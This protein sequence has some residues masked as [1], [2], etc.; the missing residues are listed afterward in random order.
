[1]SIVQGTGTTR[2]RT[3]NR[4]RNFLL[5]AALVSIIMTLGLASAYNSGGP[6]STMGHSVEELELDP[7]YIDTG[8]DRIGIGVAGPD[9]KVHIQAD[10]AN[11]QLKLQRTGSLT[12]EAW[13]YVNEDVLRFASD[14]GLGSP[15]YPGLMG[16]DLSTG[17]VGIGA[18]SPSGL[19][20]VSSGTS[21]DAE[22][23]LEAD[24]D[25]NNENDNP[26]IKLRQDG[27]LT[28]LNFGFDNSNFGN[29]I[30][31]IGRV[32]N[33]V[34]YWDTLTIDTYT[35]NIGINTTNP[36]ETLEVDGNILAT[37][38]VCDSV[39]CIGSGAAGADSDWAAVGGGDPTLG[40]DIYH[41]GN[42]GIGTNSP[43]GKL[44]V[45]DDSAAAGIP[46]ILSNEDTTIGNQGWL[47]FKSIDDNSA[48]MN[49]AGIKTIYL[50]RTPGAIEGRLDF[51]VSAQDGSIGSPKLSILQN[52]NVGIG[53][54]NP[55]GQLDIEANVDTPL[56][57]MTNPADLTVDFRIDAAG[58][59]FHIDTNAQSD[60]I[61]I[62]GPT[63]NV[64][65]GT[66]T[67]SQSWMSP[68]RFS[69]GPQPLPRKV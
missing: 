27:A 39:G 59:D 30:I 14:D 48:E 8:N 32:Y 17:R 60:A 20:H 26:I 69:W 35:G 50:S 49:F 37:G 58:N 41:T 1:M 33:A 22:L 12:G 24:T 25:N 67:P 6:A 29:N 56:L 4:N 42:V 44:H 38:T 55:N 21:G 9:G 13:I 18:T 45:V 66:A 7:L 5:L 54:A 64:G 31:G 53:K 46:L 63:G 61:V 34:E 10:A 51:H 57:R 3:A 40:G 19:L 65:I 23:Y 11:A 28:G 68:V 15:T 47:L 43:S 52:G 36:S 62:D 2:T 16:I